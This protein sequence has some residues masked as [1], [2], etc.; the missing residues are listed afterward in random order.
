VN[1]YAEATSAVIEQII[2][3][4]VADVARADAGDTFPGQDAD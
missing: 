2:G 1:C 4:A 3:E